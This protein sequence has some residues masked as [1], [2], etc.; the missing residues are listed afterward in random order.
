MEKKVY[1]GIIIGVI[2]LAIFIVYNVVSNP[3]SGRVISDIQNNLD[4]LNKDS[5]PNAQE[6]HWTHMPLTYSFAENSSCGN[7]E[8]N[9]I[10]RAFD[11][12]QKETNNTVSFK[13]VETN[14]DIIIDCKKDF[15]L[16]KAAGDYQVGDGA[17]TKLEGNRILSGA[18]NFYIVSGTVNAGSCP[19]ANI[20][21]HEILHTFGLGHTSEKNNIMNPIVS[22]C[23]SHLNPDILE[24]LMLTYKK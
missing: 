5:F 11:T 6:L 23:P 10:L 7:S 14:G 18:M 3:A 1:F 15:N 12:I 8:P 4:I 20:E 13:Q 21:V 16:D 2:A 19:Y 22:Y 17:I 9:Y 24:K